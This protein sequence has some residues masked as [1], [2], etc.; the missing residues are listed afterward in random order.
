MRGVHRILLSLGIVASAITSPLGHAAASTVIS[1][2]TADVI[3]VDIVQN[4][5]YVAVT[6]NDDF[7]PAELSIAPVGMT[8]GY[9]DRS[10]R[11]VKVIYK[12]PIRFMSP[13]EYALP[14]LQLDRP[15]TQLACT[16]DGIRVSGGLVRFLVLREVDIP[17]NFRVELIVVPH[18]RLVTVEANWPQRWQELPRWGVRG[19]GEP[20]RLESE[21]LPG[22]GDPIKI[23][24]YTEPLLPSKRP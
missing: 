8:N 5:P 10:Q 14:N 24:I 11:Q 16:A 3:A 21:P 22:T 6:S 12:L 17:N 4:G 18:Q 13:P 23:T 19:P 2:P 15:M 20:P 7:R 9:D 1:C